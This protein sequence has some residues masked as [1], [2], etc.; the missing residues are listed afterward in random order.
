MGGVMGDVGALRALLLTEE[1]STIGSFNEVCR[2][3]GIE[4]EDRPLAQE[5][6]GQLEERKYAAVI[7][8]FDNP[9]AA[10]KYL[11]MLQQ[12]RLNKNAVVVAVAANAKN[13][14]RA[15]SCRV[16][17][18]LKRPIQDTEIRRALHAAYDLMIVD[19]RRKF[20]S[21]KI[22][23]VRV[24]FVS[25]GGTFECS[26]VNISSNGVAIYSSTRMKPAESIDLEIVLPDGFVVLASGIVVWDDGNGKSGINLQ[27][28]TPGVRQ[29][30]D[31][32]LDAQAAAITKGD[33]TPR[34]FSNI[35]IPAANQ[36]A[37]SKESVS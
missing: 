6:P 16:H 37:I 25:S 15:L 18:V 35:I 17:F 22:L 21:S 34:D 30:L 8:N 31:A 28:R 27:C 14:E 36:S 3:L 5:F 33:L 24:R 26:T 4:T 23:P 12:S 11:P 2:E 13:L 9:E 1:E 20:R 32:W 19:R 10:E 29:R 7:V